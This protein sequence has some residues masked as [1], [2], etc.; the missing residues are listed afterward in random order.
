MQGEKWQEKLMQ[1]PEIEKILNV[2]HFFSR[3]N[4]VYGVDV[5]LKTGQT[6]KVVVK[7]IMDEV[8]SREEANVL[9][10]LLMHRMGVPQVIWHI[11]G[12]I[13]MEYIPGVLLVDL[14]GKRQSDSNRWIER[15]AVWL[16]SYHQLTLNEAGKVLLIQDANLRNFIYYENEFYGIDF[17]SKHWGD[18]ARDL[19]ELCSFIL[20]NDPS[21]AEWKFAIVEALIRYY[22]KE[23]GRK[24]EER[25]WCYIIQALEETIKRRPQQE[26]V[27]REGIESIKMMKKLSLLEGN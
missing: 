12:M 18:P 1:W 14:L 24:I 2:E 21:F 15:L 22:Q 20:N 23:T 4:E 3:R 6:L 8:K 17:E 5:R 19:G 16:A 10:C 7:V 9:R 27:L 11:P 25:V 13:V 26:N